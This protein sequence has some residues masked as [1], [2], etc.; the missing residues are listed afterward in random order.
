MTNDRNENKWNWLKKEN[1]YLAHT[2]P[3]SHK[4]CNILQTSIKLQMKYI[5]CFHTLIASSSQL[6]TQLQ[7]NLITTIQLHSVCQ[8]NAYMLSINISTVAHGNVFQFMNNYTVN[9][10]K[11]GIKT[12]EEKA[13]TTDTFASGNFA[14]VANQIVA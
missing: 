4:L 9:Y 3:W 13:I 10:C 6:L 14:S 5:W 1:L 11:A 8:L 2:N 12:E 7:F